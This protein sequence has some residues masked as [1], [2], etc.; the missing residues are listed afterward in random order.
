[1]TWC[2]W[3]IFGRTSSPSRCHTGI[4]TPAE[5]KGCLPPTV[6]S[7]SCKYRIVS[8]SLVST[9]LETSPVQAFCNHTRPL[10]VYAIMWQRCRTAAITCNRSGLPDRVSA[11][12]EGRCAA[13]IKLT[14]LRGGEWLGVTGET[15]I[16]WMRDGS[17]E[18]AT[19]HSARLSKSPWWRICF[20]SLTNVGYKTPLREI[21]EY[22]F[23]ALKFKPI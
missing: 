14:P 21:L 10:L 15:H 18:D 4:T 23:A 9:H 22:Y 2:T 13:F 19:P 3:V 7:P 8:M 12:Q 1:M 16:V 17:A 6:T 11:V 5:G 20:N